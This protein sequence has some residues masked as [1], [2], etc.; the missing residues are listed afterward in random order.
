MFSYI[1]TFWIIFCSII[2]LAFLLLM[3]AC[4]DGLFIGSCVLGS[5]ILGGFVLTV[6]GLFTLS[7]LVTVFIGRK[8]SRKIKWW[9]P[10][11]NFLLIII[12]LIVLLMTWLN[13]WI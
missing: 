5:W 1:K 12:F 8:N 2:V 4:S 6:L 7:Q 9:I 3:Q 10:L 11:A 13:K